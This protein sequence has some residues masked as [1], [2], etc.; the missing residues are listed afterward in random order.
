MALTSTIIY[1]H[2][3][4]APA[5]PPTRS[6]RSSR[7]SPRPPGWRSRPA[8]SPWPAGSWPAS[9][10]TSPRPSGCRDALAELGALATSARRPTSSSC[11]TSAPRSRS[12]RRPSPSSRR[13]GYALPDYPDEPADRRERD[14]PGPLRQGQG[15]RRQ[16]GAPRGQL[17]PPGPG[18]GEGSTPAST[19]TRWARGRPT[20]R[21]TWPRWATTTSAPTSSRSP[22]ADGRRPPHRARRRRRHHH[23]AEGRPRRCSPARSSTPPFMRK[24]RAR[25]RSSP[26]RSPTPRPRACCSRCTSRP[27]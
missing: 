9:R 19:R 14:D 27:R 25:R 8:T 11:P 3:D 5:W 26:S 23:R 17:R 6:S 2:T 22:I 18:V 12:S 16:P 10:S 13:K 7:P 15:Q 4:E 21:P 1:T 24:R 20:R